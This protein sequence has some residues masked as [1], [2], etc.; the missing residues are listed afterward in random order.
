MNQKHFLLLG[1]LF[2]CIRLLGQNPDFVQNEGITSPLHQAHIGR[3]TFMERVIPIE[4]YKESDF[5]STFEWGDKKD[6]NIRTFM[7]NSLTNY[8]HPLAPEMPAEELVQ[9]G[10]FQF[11]FIVDGQLVYVENLTPGAG[12]PEFKNTKTV[13]RVPLMSTQNEDS[14]GRFLWNRFLMS[15]G[16]VALGIGVHQL[17]IELRAYLPTPEI[18]VSG[19]IA[20]GEL[21]VSVPAKK[22]NPKQIAVQAIRPQTDFPIST[23]SLD[24][25]KLEELNTKI[26]DGTFK[27][28][29]SI[30][31]IQNNALLVEEYFNGAKRNTLH[32]TR[33]VGKSV[34]GMLVGLAIDN[35]HL[36]S[37]NQ[38]LSEFYDL[39]KYK[40]DSPPKG[41]V[42]LKNLLT[43][44]S[45]FLGSD[46]DEKSPGNEE[47]MYPTAN[48]VEF[49]LNLPMED[50]RVN[51]EKWDYFTAGMILL[52]DILNTAVPGGLEKFA[53]SSLFAPLGIT[54]YK[55]Q[56]TPQNVPNTAGG[57]GM[58]A[59]D[60]AKLGL[61]YAN[62]GQVNGKQ[63][64]AADWVAAS[65]SH[66]LPI[67]GRV[68]EYY[69]YLFWNMTY[70]VAGQKHEV[71][72]ASGNGGNRIFIFKDRPLVIVV[73]A[74]A[75]NKPY[76]HTQVDRMM[77]EYLIP[78]VTK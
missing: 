67:P 24:K 4:E 56:H 58:R 64:I 28:I 72:Y 37:E 39:K 18:K 15:G 9:K 55:W 26:A 36:K 14:W 49:T 42:T 35:G 16:Q 32:D 51:G 27:D 53:E 62:G 73:T 75:Y 19:L 3:I 44:S 45:G 23:A 65:L 38:R 10:N 33:S 61:L 69:G 5:L 31:V 46:T 22:V 30:V 77:R 2:W 71:Y 48:W 74:T 47:N 70:L 60:L 78:A 6:L 57:I 76:A 29:S 12:G 21:Q 1:L 8:L 34:A 25:T 7:G 40:N 68:E 50:S 17:K 11:T 59:L 66:Q 54:K 13:F 20:A 63:V 43:M 52:G 41:Q